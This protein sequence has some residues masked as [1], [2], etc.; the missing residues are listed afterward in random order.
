MGKITGEVQMKKFIE[1]CLSSDPLPDDINDEIDRWHNSDS[2]EQLHDFLGMTWDEYKLWVEN[3]KTLNSIIEKRL[4]QEH[5][6]LVD[7]EFDRGLSKGELHRLHHVRALL[8]K[9]QCDQIN[10]EKTMANKH[11]CIRD[12]GYDPYEFGVVIE[13]RNDRSFPG[14]ITWKRERECH[15]GCNGFDV[16]DCSCGGKCACHFMKKYLGIDLFID[17]IDGFSLPIYDVSDKTLFLNMDSWEEPSNKRILLYY[18][19]SISDD[20][21]ENGISLFERRFKDKP[22]AI[23]ISLNLKDG[24]KVGIIIEKNT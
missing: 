19:N 13:P 18:Y 2:Q 4:Y 12:L 23:R 5:G 21:L 11:M 1:R 3:P 7:K 16:W 8:D 22:D 20:V 24:L 6:E 14:H 10:R 15:Y 9:I 17:T